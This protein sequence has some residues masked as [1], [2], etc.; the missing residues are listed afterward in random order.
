MASTKSQTLTYREPDWHWDPF[1]VLDLDRSILDPEHGAPKTNS[2][3][4]LPKNSPARHRYNLYSRICRIAQSHPRD[5]HPDTL[6]DVAHYYFLW[7]GPR[8][9]A[10]A[11]ELQVETWARR[12]GCWMWQIHAQKEMVREN[13]RLRPLEK[14]RLFKDA[15]ESLDKKAEDAY[16]KLQDADS[17]DAELV[18]MRGTYDELEAWGKE[19][20]KQ[21]QEDDD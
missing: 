19:F 8:G 2:F 4:Q 10:G 13:A 5:I 6:R 3:R 21:I 20:E 15:G 9:N 16:K 14:R 12:L 18:I 17:A 1:E 7:A 11:F